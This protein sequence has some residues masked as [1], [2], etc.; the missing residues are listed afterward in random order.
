[1]AI[2][3]AANQKFGLNQR[4]IGR[5]QNKRALVGALNGLKDDLHC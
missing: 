1:M 3:T 2:G 5:F 4:I